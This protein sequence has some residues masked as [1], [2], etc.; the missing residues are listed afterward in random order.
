MILIL[1]PSQESNEECGKSPVKAISQDGFSGKILSQSG[2]YLRNFMGMQKRK[3]LLVRTRILQRKKI[4]AHLWDTLAS[5][6]CGLIYCGIRLTN[7]GVI[8]YKF[9]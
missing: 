7:E 5:C 1:I 8:F 2:S 4:E 3:I 9:G 6:L